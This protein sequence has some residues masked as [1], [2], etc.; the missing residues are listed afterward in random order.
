MKPSNIQVKIIVI[1]YPPQLYVEYHYLHILALRWI[2]LLLLLRYI[3]SVTVQDCKL[4]LRL[5]NKYYP[6]LFPVNSK[7]I[8]I[9]ESLAAHFLKHILESSKISNF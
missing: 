9:L 4:I 1:L 6:I 2:L 5:S 8:I 7:E 3:I